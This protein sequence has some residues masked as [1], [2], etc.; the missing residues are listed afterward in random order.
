MMEQLHPG[1][2]PLR[3]ILIPAGDGYTIMSCTLLPGSRPPRQNPWAGTVPAILVI[4]LVIVAGCSSPDPS[5]EITQAPTLQTPGREMPV[6]ATPPLHG[7][8]FSPYMDGQAPGNPAVLSTSQIRER[9]D[10]VA[11]YATWIRT[12]GC[13]SGLEQIPA[14]AR[15]LQKN[16][17]AG[18]WLGG[19]STA[20]QRQ[21][22]TLVGLAQGGYVD[23]AVVGNEAIYGG[24][25]TAGQ[26]ILYLRSVRSRVP[27][28][29]KVTTAEP[30]STWKKYPGL[31]TEV[32][33]VYV[34]LYP[35]WNGIA[36]EDAVTNI[37]GEYQDAV[38]LAGGRPV[39]ISETGWPSAG[40]PHGLALP[41]GENAGRYYR[42]FTAWAGNTSAEYFYFEAF[43]E[44]W[45]G[46]NTLDTERHWG[47]WDS[48]GRRK[49]P[50]G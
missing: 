22:E 28:T 19:D 24:H 38:D 50:L 27:A 32:D 4:A 41:S 3:Q 17:S 21:I 47:L 23:V 12:Y 35:F 30:L 48:S 25:L 16:T 8:C 15:S 33:L 40:K 39:V 5:R 13:D 49:F 6:P 11:A 29:V 46:S 9:L 34:N 10:I 42:E 26:L 18:V 36:V 43:D 44:Q 2:D 7:I 20:D 1:Q 14:L 45:K 31:I 37:A